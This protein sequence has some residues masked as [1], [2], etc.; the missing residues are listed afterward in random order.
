MSTI[1]PTSTTSPSPT[2]NHLLAMLPTEEYA[3][4]EGELELIEM[5]L[6]YSLYEP[7]IEMEHVYFPVDAI[8]SLLHLTEDGDTT[9][10]A[11][12]GFEGIVGVPVFMGGATS[13][14]RAVVTASGHA[15]CL[16]AHVL[17]TEFDR[18][19]T[20]QDLLLLYTHALLTQMAQ[21]AICNRHHSVEQQV[22]RRLLLSHDRLHG[23]ELFMT[24]ELIANTLG[25]RREGVCEAARKL[26]KAALIRYHR[27]H[28]YIRDRAGLKARSC[29]CYDV[30]K[31][32][33]DR[34]LPVETAD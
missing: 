27:G 13:P 5:P 2:D 22:C 12:V 24:Q 1:H 7:N 19:G 10:I 3:L 16:P 32:E 17:M 18:G 33:Y 29:E 23:S 14:S 25:V 6:G 21:T 11:V 34:V 28:V 15:Y 20:M 30:V 8:V 31:R 4:L 26:Q 9:E